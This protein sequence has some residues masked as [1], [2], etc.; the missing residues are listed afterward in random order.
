MS[1]KNSVIE[2]LVF[3]PRFL[4]FSLKFPVTKVSCGPTFAVAL[5]KTGDLLSWGAGECGQLGTGRCTKREIPTKVDI[6]GSSGKGS[7]TLVDVACG[8]GH[9]IAAAL[10]GVVYGWGMNKSGQLG[11]SD[12]VTRHTPTAVAAGVGDRHTPTFYSLVFA[13]GH[14]SAAITRDGHLHTWGSNAHGR[15]MHHTSAAAFDNEA[16]ESPAKLQPPRISIET[17]PRL[18][19]DEQ[20]KGCRVHSFAFSKYSSAA[21]V[22]TT[23]TKVLQLLYFIVW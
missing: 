13:E 7:V 5:T 20:I 17:A 19:V 3:S 4:P 11:L 15:L 2:D 21:L 1:L 10:D 22:H 8:A 9:C 16:R 12:T 6:V 23:V 18:V 14:S